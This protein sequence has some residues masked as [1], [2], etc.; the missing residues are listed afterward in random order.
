[1]D[2]NQSW[3]LLQS[4]TSRIYLVFWGNHMT[5]YH[6]YQEI[7][8][9][10]HVWNNL[11][12]FYL[13]LLRVDYIIAPLKVLQ[14]LKD[15]VTAPDEKYSFV[16]RLSPQSA[17]L[18]N[19]SKEEVCFLFIFSLHIPLKHLEFRCFTDKNC[20]EWSQIYL[21]YGHKMQSQNLILVMDVYWTVIEKKK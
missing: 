13:S 14:S 1:M 21:L 4:E 9:R 18:Y 15:S 16:R 7:L 3:W 19:F 12:R 20:E 17:A 2:I 11:W 10:F 5:F 8:D 6:K